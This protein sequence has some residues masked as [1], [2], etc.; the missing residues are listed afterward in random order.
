MADKQSIVT[1]RKSDTKLGEF[2]LGFFMA[3]AEYLIKIGTINH[4]D[5]NTIPPRKRQDYQRLPHG[6][7]AFVLCLYLFDMTLASHAIYRVEEWIRANP[8][9]RL[10]FPEINPIFFTEDRIARTL[11]AIG[12]NVANISLDQSINIVDAFKLDLKTVYIDLT[13]FTVYGDYDYQDL[14]HFLMDYSPC[15]KSGKRNK[16]TMS[17]I[18]MASDD[19]GVPFYSET[20]KGS[21]PDTVCYI[22][23]IDV[24]RKIIGS[25]TLEET[26]FVGD[27]KSMATKTQTH[28]DNGNGKYVG[29]KYKTTDS[30]IHDLQHKINVSTQDLPNLLKT[31]EAPYKQETVEIDMAFIHQNIDNSNLSE[32]LLTQHGKKKITIY[33]GCD[34]E[35]TYT[36]TDKKDHYLRELLVHSSEKS[37]ADE[38][39]LDRD[40][41]LSK[42]AL[43]RLQKGA[44][45]SR[46]DS[47]ESVIGAVEKA[48]NRNSCLPFFSYNV[49]E[50]KEI[51]RK[52][53]KRG[54]HSDKSQFVETE[55]MH[56]EL[57]FEMNKQAIQEKRNLC[58][59]FILQTNLTPEEADNT[60]LLKL[61]KGQDKVEKTFAT[62]KSVLHVA[63]LCLKSTRRIKGLM[64]LYAT[65]SQIVTL[66]DREIAVNMK[67][68]G[69]KEIFGIIPRKGT[70]R[71]HTNFI[72]ATFEK[73]NCCIEKHPTGQYSVEL[74]N[75]TDQLYQLL[76][77]AS[78]DPSSY[79]A[80]ATV[81]KLTAWMQEYPEDFNS[82][83]DLI[84]NHT[85]RYPPS[86]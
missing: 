2:K 86:D 82:S 59:F 22:P 15:P 28:I 34:A 21:D 52:A 4:V 14:G 81:D 39:K 24:F 6:I 37:K 30:A 78:V 23:V 73:V 18:T 17:K 43:A 61:Y 3:V 5:N 51:I 41:E 26:I 83:M 19:G 8:F 20:L 32:I 58:G 63:P 74:H 70:A 76:D 85:K 68:Q 67:K 44:S 42:K 31:T 45:G 64:F 80:H 11:D 29:M 55:K 62:D 47:K 16:K 72:S 71:P 13:N 12:E 25:E 75:L 65:L 40:L 9:L 46:Y 50:V 49:T 36:G 7:V 10:L 56:Y 60:K 38:H 35:G 84:L 66:I 27:S 77:L 57:T 69:I 79:S 53:T 33:R 54:R 48:L 1:V